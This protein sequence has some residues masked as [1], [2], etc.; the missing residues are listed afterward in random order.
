[1]ARK[2]RS[3]WCRVIAAKL[4]SSMVDNRDYYGNKRLELAGALMSLLFEDLFKRLNFEVQ[5]QAEN[6]LTKAQRAATFDVARYAIF[7][8]FRCEK[9]AITGFE[10]SMATSNS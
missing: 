2:I 1:M 9:I 5:R 7:S 3:I 4:D 10:K 8:L 6:T